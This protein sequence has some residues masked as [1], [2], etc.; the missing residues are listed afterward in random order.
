LSSSEKKRPGR[1]LHFIG[2]AGSGMSALAQYH[3]VRGGKVSGSDR[4]F[5]HGERG[6]IRKRLAEAGIVIT[7]QDGSGIAEGCAAVVVSTAVESDIPDVVAAKRLNIPVIHRSELLAEFIG[8]KQAIAVTGTSGKSTVTAMIFEIL[9]GAGKNP[10]VITGGALAKL[11]ADGL[12]GNA[13][14]G[15]GPHLVVEADESD[16]SLVRYRPWCSLILN[17]QRDHKEPDEVAEMFSQLRIQTEGPLIIGSDP[18]LNFLSPGAI[19]FGQA[20]FKPTDVLLA[21]DHSTFKLGGVSFMLPAP[22][23]YNVLNA[24]AAITACV[25]TGLPLKSMVAPLRTFHGV[26]R[27]FQTVGTARNIHVIDDFAHNPDKI[28]AALSAAHLQHRRVLAV[29]QPHGFGPT[30]FLRDDLIAAFKSALSADDILWLPEIYYAGGT[31]VRDISS[32]DIVSGIREGGRDARFVEGRRALAPVIAA[33]ARDGDLVLV[34]GARDP[35]LTDFC[36]EILTALDPD[37]A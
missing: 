37:D 3:V 24:T 30:R 23:L 11:E 8:D 18:A 33:E 6:H 36:R 12:L 17:L 21:P 4:A 35:S 15:D 14:A 28:R 34:M 19:R 32:R 2:V 26:A 1:W 27:R 9:A 20:D 22:G 31:V 16:G 29:F 13:Y 10:S 25:Q 5:D 7:S